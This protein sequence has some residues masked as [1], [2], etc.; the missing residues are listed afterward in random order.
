MSQSQIHPVTMPKWGLSMQE[1]KVNRW[2]ADIGDSL[3]A[4]AEVV[5]VESDKIA[6]VIE[7]ASGGVLRRKIAKVDDV[8][9]IG[10]LLGLIAD[11]QVADAE[12]DAFVAEFQSRFVPGEIE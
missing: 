10:A 6:G 8:L 3:Q 4:G 2:L 7:A 1:G 5:E 12:I 9:P 11:N